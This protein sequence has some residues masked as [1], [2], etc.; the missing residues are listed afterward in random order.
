M[1]IINQIAF[2]RGH[3]STLRLVVGEL[4]FPEFVS[5]CC[6]SHVN[7]LCVAQRSNCYKVAGTA[8]RIQ[9]RKCKIIF[10]RGRKREK[11]FDF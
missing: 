7:K 5:F 8:E 6:V 3:S 10:F 11:K 1:L 9:N 4:P 2:S